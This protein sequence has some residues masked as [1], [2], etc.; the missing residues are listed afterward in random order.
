MHH[1]GLLSAGVLFFPAN[2]F[3]HRGH[4]EWPVPVRGE[5]VEM[6]EATLVLAAAAL[7]LL[8]HLVQAERFKG[9]HKNPENRRQSHHRK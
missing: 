5:S 2:V 3:A 9:K 6:I 4:V 7:Y 1:L 8:V